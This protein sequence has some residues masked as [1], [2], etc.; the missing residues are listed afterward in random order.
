MKLSIIIPIYNEEESIKELYGEIKSSL[1]NN[2]LSHEIIAINDGSRDKSLEILKEIANTD[3]DFKIIDF[4]KNYG[5]TAAISAGID[6]AQGDILIPIDADL[7]N[8]PNDIPKLLAEIDKGF[9]VVSGWRKNRHDN[10]T[11]KI[12][13]KIANW[14]ISHI[15]KVK[16]HDYGCT[17]KAYKKEIVKDIRFYGEMHRF[18]PAYASWY[19]AKI[20]EIVVNHR[21]RKYGKTKYGISRTFRVVLDLVTVK[22]LT[23]YLTKPI[24]FFG[25]AGLISLFFGFGSGIIAVILKL[26]GT[27]FNKTP[28]PL[29][30]VFLILVGIQ[31]VLMGL[32]AEILIRVYYEPQ[33]KSPYIIK[34]KI[35][36]K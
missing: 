12:P 20:S 5:Q 13:S 19:G 30:T 10:L 22:F 31:F 2:S 33:Q 15:T 17:I 14:L 36:F 24:H 1:N 28:L 3:S 11:R 21:S 16:L 7:Q 34:N 18:M 27:N 9:D 8:D 32:L 29:L 6:L 25:K 35:N 23:T 4:R 26:Q